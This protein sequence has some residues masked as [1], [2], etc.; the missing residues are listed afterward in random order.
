MRMTFEVL[1]HFTDARGFSN[2]T[3]KCTLGPVLAVVK[4]MFDF[5]LVACSA[6]VLL[7]Y[8]KFERPVYGSKFFFKQIL[9]LFPLESCAQK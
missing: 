5:I 3:N 4:E 8:V 1:K 9:K 6:T 2:F 7:V